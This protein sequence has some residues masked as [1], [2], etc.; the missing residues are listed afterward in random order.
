MKKT[1]ATFVL[2]LITFV[3]YGQRP[4]RFQDSVY[5]RP[6]KTTDEYSQVLEMMSDGRVKRQAKL[7]EWVEWE[8]N[9]I[10]EL[11]EMTSRLDRERKGTPIP[12]AVAFPFPKVIQ[13][14]EFT[15]ELLLEPERGFADYFL[16]NEDNYDVNIIKSSEIANAIRDKVFSMYP[17]CDIVVAGLYGRITDMQIRCIVSEVN[18][19][20]SLQSEKDRILESLK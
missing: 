16:V 18:Y 1:I 19:R 3:V 2:I 13:V 20:N 6:E 15:Y 11:K 9:A 17:E 12:G 10:N 4:Q 8:N 14:G 5:T 7:K